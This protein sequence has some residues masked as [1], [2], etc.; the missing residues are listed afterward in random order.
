M[1]YSITP[2]PTCS[3]IAF[4]WSDKLYVSVCPGSVIKLLT[5]ILKALLSF[6]AF[7]TPFTNKFGITFVYKLPGPITIASA[8]AIA[9]KTPGAGLQLVG[10]INILFILLILLVTSSSIFSL[11]SIIVPSSSSAHIFISSNVTGSTFP[12]IFNTSFDCFM[13]SAKSP[14]NSFIPNKYI[15]PKERAF[16]FPVLNL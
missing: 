3:L 8:S 15:S 2:S 6:I 1:Q 5:Y 11:F 7:V 10:F 9:S 14:Y 16:S 12:V 4:I 13:D